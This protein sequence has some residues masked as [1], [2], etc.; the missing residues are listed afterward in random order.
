MAN[1]PDA[2]CQDTLYFNPAPKECNIK[3]VEAAPDTL[4]KTPAPLNLEFQADSILFT[5]PGEE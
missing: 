3:F 1:L 5:D 2:V 4:P